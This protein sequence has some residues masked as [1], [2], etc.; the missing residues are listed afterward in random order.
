MKFNIFCICLLLLLAAPAWAPAVTD[1]GIVGEVYPVAESDVREEMKQRAVRNWEKLNKEYQEKINTYQP[2]DLHRLP[3]AS[4][5]RT[6]MVDMTYTLDR[7]L[8]D[9]QGRVVY[10]KGYA[11]NPLDY[12]KMSIGLVVIDGSDPAQVEWY[13]ASPYQKNHQVK[14]LL[15]GGQA[16]AL[17]T[18]L[19]RAVFYLNKD[20]AERLRLTAVPCV[21]LQK[22]RYMQV[23]EFFI[24]E[25]Q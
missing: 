23:T 8:K 18:E 16:Q 3:K 17:I 5:D 15:S 9:Q 25:A 10:P 13:K 22:D 20:L 6:F 2:A 24:K 12:L 4:R 1:L 21:A 7:D 11:F 19:D 14:L